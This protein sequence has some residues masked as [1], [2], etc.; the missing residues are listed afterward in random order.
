MKVGSRKSEDGS[1]EQSAGKEKPGTIRIEKKKDD[2]HAKKRTNRM[3]DSCG[4]FCRGL[5]DLPKPIKKQGGGKWQKIDTI[6]KDALFF[7]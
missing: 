1:K 3:H 6:Q 4:I 5:E 7:A 2:R